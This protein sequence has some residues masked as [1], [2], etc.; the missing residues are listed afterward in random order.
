M[1]V[2]LK[3]LDDGATIKEYE[4]REQEFAAQA[5]VRGVTNEDVRYMVRYPF[6]S[7]CLP[8]R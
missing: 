3:R 2:G 5:T 4:E 1:V 7:S 6:L 8:G